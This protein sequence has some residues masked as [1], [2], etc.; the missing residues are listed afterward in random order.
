MSPQNPPLHTEEETPRP[1]CAP[2]SC[3]ALSPDGLT[4]AFT[5]AQMAA[6]LIERGEVGAGGMLDSSITQTCHLI[7]QQ[8]EEYQ[9]DTQTGHRRGMTL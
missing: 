4:S 2:P 8:N 5:M 9:A 7:M 3:A 1:S 6:S